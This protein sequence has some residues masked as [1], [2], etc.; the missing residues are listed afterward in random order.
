MNNLLLIPDEITNDIEMLSWLEEQAA[1][2]DYHN[3]LAYADIGHDE[4]AY[5]PLWGIS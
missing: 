1:R 4:E 3:Q 5:E 2:F